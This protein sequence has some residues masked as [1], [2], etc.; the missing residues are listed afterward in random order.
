MEAHIFRELVNDLRDIAKKFYGHDSLREKIV[1][2]LSI[3]VH[4]A[5]AV[6]SDAPRGN[7]SGTLELILTADSG[8]T[9]SERHRISPEQWGKIQAALKNE[10]PRGGD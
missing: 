7:A 1:R 6:K 8:Y 4:P 5:P 10:S 3:D 9:S 2:R